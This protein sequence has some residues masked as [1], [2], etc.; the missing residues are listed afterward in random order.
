MKN[1]Y[2][3]FLLMF[4]A[5]TASAQ[6]TQWL[7]WFEQTNGLETP[8]YD[9][10]LEFCHRLDS[11]SSIINTLNF[12]KSP[13]GQDLIALIADKDGLDS[14]EQIKQ[15]GRLILMVNACIHSGEPDGKDAGLVLLRDMAINGKYKELLQNVSI[16][17][18]PVF[19]ADGHERFSAYN[20]INQNG[21]KEMGWRTTATN[22][23]L[24]RDFL[25]VQAQETRMWLGLY[26]HWLPDFFIDCHT[27][28]GA[29]YQYVVT[30]SL[31]A[32][33]NINPALS[34]WQKETYLPFVEKKMFASGNPIFPYV[35]FRNWHDPR[36]GLIS[37]IAPPIL[38]QG[39]VAM[40][41]RPSL[42]IETHMLKPY[43]QRVLATNAM[44]RF[45][46]E[47]MNKEALQLKF[48]IQTA[49]QE[50]LSNDFRNK[51]YPLQYSTSPNDSIMVEF[52]GV[53]YRIT[54]SDL[55]GGDWFQ[56]GSKKAIFKIPMF[57]QYQPMESTKLPKAYII[58][59][60]WQDIIERLKIHGVQ[61]QTLTETKILKVKSYKFSNVKQRD[62][63]Y[64][65]C[66]TV[67]FDQ[68]EIEE[69]RTYYPGSVI[70][71][72]SQPLA[73]IIISMLEPKA[74]GSLLSWGFFNTIFEQK[75]YAESYVME[76]EARKMLAQS[77]ELRK[78]FE[79]KK[80]SDPS[81]A[82]DPRAIYN[83]FY[84]RSPWFDNRLNVYPVG[85]ITE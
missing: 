50:V 83:W 10:T 78:E 48:A 71:P 25:K 36:S 24:N 23:N 46:L 29:D 39:Y 56:Y 85:K 18:I 28:D 77:S 16:L 45:T 42:L 62:Q 57:K 19:S 43:K 58:P 20:R 53:E 41:N 69:E 47:M 79:T 84:Q 67:T 17:F 81:F 15:K 80:A 44:I 75:E 76:V 27:T 22:L 40:R 34:K 66:Q 61:M 70:I 49:D 14:P 74:G 13:Q 30:Y 35:V 33:G 3:V 54:K 72:V 7:T 9:Q 8:R 38:S 37:Q 2:L 31:E 52:L 64:E 1:K 26:N 65:G 32:D 51:E 59:I 21:P 68:Q 5:T 60:E 63:S 73:K 4:V 6:S 11:A 82:K 55:T 12:G